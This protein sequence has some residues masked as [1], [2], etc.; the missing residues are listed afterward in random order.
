MPIEMGGRRDQAIAILDAVAAQ[1]GRAPDIGQDLDTA[2]A[3][4]QQRL[5][6]AVEGIERGE[7]P[8]RPEDP[9]LC[10]WCPYPSVCRKDY[11]GD[12]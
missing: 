12:E 4:G 8:V 11:V 5:I 9:F 1:P 2:V 10:T 7:F 3:D 6:A